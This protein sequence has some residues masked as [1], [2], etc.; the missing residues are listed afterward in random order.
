MEILEKILDDFQPMLMNINDMSEENRV[1]L[2]QAIMKA[3]TSDEQVK[4]ILDHL[5]KMLEEL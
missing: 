3:K 2:K 5:E 4:V 1:L